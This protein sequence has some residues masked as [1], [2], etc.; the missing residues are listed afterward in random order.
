M[1]L[2]SSGGNPSS[3]NKSISK[4]LQICEKFDLSDFW[5]IRNPL[6]KRFTFRKNHFSGFIQRRLDFFFISNS[7]QESIKKTDIL[8]SFCSDHS[9]IFI[10]FQ[11]NQDITLG[12]HFWKFNNSLIQDE[13]YLSEMKEHIKFIINSFD[14]ILGNNPHT[15]WEF[16][17]YEI[18]KFTIQY[19]KVKAK[20]RREKTKTLEENL[21]TLESDLKNEENI[22]QYNIQREEL[23]MTYDEISNG[24]KIRSRC[25]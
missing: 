21:K 16:L 12:K 3:K 9:P 2:E 18:R 20:K 19:S 4:V 5:R 13:N 17:K 23:N 10:S 8:P 11:K 24:I 6:C 1:L 22:L 7:L 25:N 14:T 15:Q